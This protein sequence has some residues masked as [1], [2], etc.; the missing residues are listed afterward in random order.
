MAFGQG[1]ALWLV[2]FVGEC[3]LW[4]QTPGYVL[5]NT[6][7]SEGSGNSQ[8][9]SP[10]RVAV[11]ALG[12]VWVADQGNNRL[13]EFDPNGNFLQTL[14]SF[15][16]AA[17]QFSG[18]QG[19][20]VDSVG[21]IWV[22]DS[23]NNRVQEFN[24]SG[25]FLQMFG[26]YGSGS[27][28]IN[29]A[30]AIAV[31]RSGNVWINDWWNDRVDEFSGRGVFLQSFG[32]NGSG[33]GQFAW[34]GGLTTSLAGNVFVADAQNNRVQEFNSSG[35]YLQTI[36][37]GQLSFPNDV[38]FDPQGNLW[39]A[40]TSG[41]ALVEFN[42]GGTYL[43]QMAL[44]YSPMSLAFGPSGTLWVVDQNDNHLLEYSPVSSPS[45]W[46]VD[47]SGKWSAAGNW[48]SGLPNGVNASVLFGALITA[49]RTVTVDMAVT[50]GTLTFNSVAK[51]TLAGPQTITLQSSAGD[52]ALNVVYGTHEISANLVLAANTDVT[53]TNPTDQ[54]TLS[55]GI[56][57]PGF[58]LNVY[59]AGTLVL[60]NSNTFGGATK[61]SSGTLQLAHPL[62][63]QNST[64]NLAGGALA[65]AAGNTSPVLGG[66]AGNGNLALATVASEAVT[67][68]MG[69]NGQS[70]SYSGILS[71][72]GGLVK[73]GLGTLTVNSQSIYGGPT[74]VAGG[75]LMLQSPPAGSIG[76]HFIGNG[77][78]F[79]GTG[80]VVPISNWNNESGYAFSGS[81]LAA[82]NGANSGASFS[83]AGAN[84]VW[85]TGS[86]NQLLNGYAASAFNPMTLTLSGIPYARYS[87]YVYVGD[88]SVGNQ[89]SATINGTTYYYAT[90]GGT[91]IT[92]AAITNTTSASYQPGNYIEVDGLSGASQTVK[93]VGTTQAYAGLCSVEIVNTAAAAGG[94][95]FLPSTTAL[96]I[97]SGGTLDLC[98]NNQ[99][100]ASLSDA[101]FGKGGNVINSFTGSTS[102]L[103]ISPSG[104]STTFSGMIQGGGA[105]GAISLAMSGNGTQVL[106]GSN[107]YTGPTTINQGTLLVNGSLASPVTVNSGG[108][109]GG[110]GRLTNVTVASGGS[111]SPGAAPSPM[112][113]SGSLSLLSGAKMD[114]ALDT[115]AD[116]DEVYMPSGPL[117]LSGQQFADFNFTWSA[118]VAP[119]TY[120]LIDAQSI[121]G[122][123]GT[124]TSGTIDGLPANIAVQGDDVVLN[125]VPEPS[126]LTLLAAGLIGLVGYGLQRRRPARRAA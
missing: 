5:V 87:M 16:S 25:V 34:M 88:S 63:V 97:A 93:M 9:N 79:L 58:G 21:N 1:V 96:S 122:S 45:A 50:A 4:A 20:T 40:S 67:L 37:A 68:N 6:I 55:G 19:V 86:A 47:A 104:G 60:A 28:Q 42:S 14:G 123:L 71:G 116:S 51:Y 24:S 39:V 114:Y 101:G 126:T 105:L 112:N 75:V 33:N 80:G 66:L 118:N 83:L 54:L 49:P 18:P 30:Q 69:G 92:Y 115:P 38:A 76:I 89:E 10:R 35:V 22:A 17:G 3:P 29:D 73:Q 107:T 100:V 2:A 61:I 90:E 56:S 7:G 113:V 72:A 12:D 121:T 102:G 91:P 124:S 48:I 53:V 82:S 8:F 81:L 11:G 111:L 84:S 23:G 36:G 62:A 78:S 125:V 65:F 27:G 44:S 41:D 98:G 74:T 110:S 13:E 109:L 119:G 46:N 94:V 15:G 120:N 64:V 32:S 106:S 57:G 31:D 85:A 117:V 70:T 52:A 26:S 108:M 103:T 77:S 43:G 59:G 95:N 99:Q